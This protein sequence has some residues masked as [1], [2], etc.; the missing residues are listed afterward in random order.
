MPDEIHGTL[1]STYLLNNENYNSVS[2]PC[3]SKDIRMIKV[4]LRMIKARNKDATTTSLFPFP[5]APF[6]KAVNDSKLATETRT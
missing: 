4:S 6:L 5:T 1:F 3:V 2:K